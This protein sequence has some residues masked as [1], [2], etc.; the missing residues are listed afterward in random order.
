MKDELTFSEME[1]AIKESDPHG[2]V[3]KM[4]SSGMDVGYV[5]ACPEYYALISRGGI[6]FD[7]LEGEMLEGLSRLSGESLTIAE[8]QRRNRLSIAFI[9]HQSDT[10]HTKI[11]SAASATEGDSV[12]GHGGPD[13]LLECNLREVEH[14]QKYAQA[15]KDR[16]SMVFARYDLRAKERET[17]EGAITSENP[18]FV[19]GRDPELVVALPSEIAC[20]RALLHWVLAHHRNIDSLQEIDIDASLQRFRDALRKLQPS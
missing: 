5:Y 16:N 10:D 9:L 6:H 20:S 1:N 11:V 14:F 12:W 13:H 7:N 2:R 3:L 18:H 19:A 15:M 8:A 4:E 17:W